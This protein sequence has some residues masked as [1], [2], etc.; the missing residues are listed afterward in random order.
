M[1]ILGTYPPVGFHF[2]VVFEIFPQSPN[3]ARFQEVTGL[4]VEMEM[5]SF[6]E[7]GQNRFTWHLPTRTRYDDITLKRGV[8]IGSGITIWCKSAL[9]DFVFSPI[10]ILISLL[11]ENHIPVFNWYVINAIPKK[12]NVSSFNAMENSVVVESLVLSY[13]YFNTLRI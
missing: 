9:E 2:L 4:N 7:A 12:W 8:F 3:D 11:D 10:N 13:Q 5:D 6:K 1:D